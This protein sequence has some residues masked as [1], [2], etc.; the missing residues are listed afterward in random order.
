MK[1]RNFRM[2]VTF[3]PA[4][5]AACDLPKPSA[6]APA[7]VQTATIAAPPKR[8]AS[9]PSPPPI[10]CDAVTAMNRNIFQ[11]NLT[12]Y[13]PQPCFITDVGA[14][15]VGLDTLDA[16]SPPIFEATWSLVHID[17]NL[18][19]TRFR[20]DESIFTAYASGGSA[21]PDGFWTEDF[22]DDGEPE[23]VF[24]YEAQP[25]E[26]AETA[27]MVAYRYANGKIAPYVPVAGWTD[28]RDV[29]DDGRIDA[30]VD[31]RAEDYG[32][33]GEYESE[34]LTAPSLVAHGVHGGFSTTD[35]FAKKTARL[36]C[37]T[38]PARVVVSS[39]GN[40][41]EAATAKNAICS[42]IWGVSEVEVTRQI[43]ASCHA[44]DCKTTGTRPALPGECFHLETLKA[45]AKEPPVVALP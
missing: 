44:F 19:M 34:T 41:D 9:E 12:S 1:C 33:C 23:I 37:P 6:Q 21:G 4:L 45:W 36:A 27:T 39:K 20:G 5:L 25:V 31:H 30:V 13:L 28:L 35:E 26:T 32:G 8:A 24:T 2:I 10:S 3:V 17:R 43:E 40:I 15:A 38:R 42:R 14:W 11:G 18:A 16:S 29:D 7:T 22:D